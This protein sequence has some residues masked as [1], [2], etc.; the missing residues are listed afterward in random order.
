MYMILIQTPAAVVILNFIG[1][2][3]HHLGDENSSGLAKKWNI[4]IA[5]KND[6]AFIYIIALRNKTICPFFQ[7]NKA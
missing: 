1:E 5:M 4:A 2:K 6:K 7:I 3:A